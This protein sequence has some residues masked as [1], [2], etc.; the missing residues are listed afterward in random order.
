GKDKT[1]VSSLVASGGRYTAGA[2]N[3]SCT[4]L[5]NMNRRESKAAGNLCMKMD[6]KVS[7]CLIISS[8]L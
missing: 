8:S 1:H 5:Y 7:V 6:D 2:S 3:F 4:F